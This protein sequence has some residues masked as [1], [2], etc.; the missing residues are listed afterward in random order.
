MAKRSVVQFIVD[1]K[2]RK[3]SV[4]VDYKAYRRLQEV[5][6]KSERGEATVCDYETVLNEWGWTDRT[7]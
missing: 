7:G 5:L 2:G 3:K 4:L 6:A 1:E